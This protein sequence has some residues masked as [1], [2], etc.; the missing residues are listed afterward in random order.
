MTCGALIFAF[1]NEHIDYVAMANWSANNIHRHLNIPVCLVTNREPPAGH[2]FD[3]VVLVNSPTGS[4][5]R[6]FADIGESVAW[7]NTNRVDACALSPWDQTLVLDADYVVASSQLKTILSSNQDFLCYR[8]ASDATNLRNFDDLN[9]FGHNRM[10]MWWATVMMFKRNNTAQLIFESMNMV[11]DNWLHYRRLYN[12][13][14]P[15]YRND[16][17]LSI[18]LN[19]VNG[20]TLSVPSIPGSLVSV[21]P[22]H[23]VTQLSQDSYRVDFLTPDQKPRYIELR[24]D[25]HAMGKQQLGVIVANPC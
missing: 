6:H 12:N 24:Q 16:H 4:G 15:N 7:H 9:Y 22:E 10:P 3:R 8:W 19:I 2:V 1:N 11:R 21:T 5:T 18:A 23:Q 13:P 14:T 20:H 17:A 25:F